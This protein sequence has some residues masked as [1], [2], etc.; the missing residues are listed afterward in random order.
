M[1]HGGALR[2]RATTLG[3]DSTLA[4]IV[5]LMRA[6]QAS[7]API[8]DLA[9]RV[10]GVFVPTVVVIAIVTFAAWMLLGAH[11]AVPATSAHAFAAAIS[12]L[13]IACPCAMGLAVP[14]AL[15]VA[16]GKGAQQG[17]LIKG[18]AALQRAGDVDTVVVD[19][20]GTITIGTSTVSCRP[21]YRRRA[22]ATRPTMPPW[23]RRLDESEHPLAE[24]IVRH[25]RAE[26]LVIAP[27]KDF[28]SLA[29]QGAEGGVDDRMVTVG[30]ARLMTERGIDLAPLRDEEAR[31]SERGMSMMFVAV[32]G[33]AAGVIAL[34]DV[35][36]PESREAVALLHEMQVSVVMLTGDNA[37]HRAG[38]CPRGW[39]RSGAG[40]RAAGREGW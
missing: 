17:I 32:S 23:Q 28:R 12:V 38:D 1:N 9:D 14:T 35:I 11:F 15:M 16:T 34:A 24:G 20:T 4:R 13:I 29:G 27:V 7:R 37:A 3:A 31:L 8:Q 36:R 10:S 40:G 21:S 18:G 25:A 22:G 19:K 2:Y 39:H 26:G 6:A 33:E 5:E 30:S